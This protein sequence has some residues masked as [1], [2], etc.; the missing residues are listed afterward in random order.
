M[1]EDEADRVMGLLRDGYGVEDISVQTGIAL[2]R[3]RRIVAALRR[4]G[5]LTKLVR[6]DRNAG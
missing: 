1:T 5:M 6:G 2:A 4:L 3:V